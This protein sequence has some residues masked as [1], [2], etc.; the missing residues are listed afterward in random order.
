MVHNVKMKR[1]STLVL[2][3][4]LTVSLIHPAGAAQKTTSMTKAF[5]QFLVE[6]NSSYTKSMEEAK[7]FYEPKISSVT[8]ELQSAQSQFSQVNQVT[9]LKTTKPGTN[10]TTVV[11]DAVN[12]PISNPD[13]K[14]PTYKSNEFTAGEVSTIYNFIGGEL[15][16]LDSFNAQMNLGMLQTIDAQ[17]KNGLI[18]LNSSA[19]YIT[20]IS[21]IRS[22][23]QNLLTLSSQ[24]KSAQNAASIAKQEA[25]GKKPIIDSAILSAKRAASTPAIYERAFMVS[26]KFQYNSQRLEELAR[27]PW[28][29]ISSLKALQDAVSV[30]KQSDLA[31]S[32]SARYSYQAA[33]KFNKTYGEIFLN[34]PEYKEGFQIVSEIFRKATRR[35]LSN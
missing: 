27:E 11:I 29:Y 13:C 1:T 15:A 7:S 18:A 5:Q 30:T 31:D 23:F 4:A 8:S 17:V 3:A 9:I 12:C 14:H 34:E 32:I 21:K 10:T 28:G 22:Q 16:F 35:S 33:D 2:I 25:F 26:F 6:A 19:A 24:Y 20:L